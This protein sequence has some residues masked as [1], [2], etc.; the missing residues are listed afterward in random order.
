MSIRAA[1]A[2]QAL[3]EVARVDSTLVASR[4]N[5]L[6]DAARPYETS[7]VNDG[8]TRAKELAASRPT[9]IAA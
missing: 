8:R 3:D 2:E 1:V 6:L 9:T 5:T 4:L 7:V